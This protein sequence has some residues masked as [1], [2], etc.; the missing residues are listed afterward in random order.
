M[1]VLDSTLETSLQGDD[2]ILHIGQNGFGGQ[3]TAI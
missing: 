1:Q 3:R 2:E